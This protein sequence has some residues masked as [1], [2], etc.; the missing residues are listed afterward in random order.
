M[1]MDEGIA[2][3]T[4]YTV[5]ESRRARRVSLRITFRGELEVVVPGRFD[6]RRIPALVAG[7]RK[8]IERTSERIREER[9]LIGQHLFDILPAKVDLPALGESWAV[10][11]VHSVQKGVRLEELPPEF[12][13]ETG[14]VLIRGDVGDARSCRNALRKWVRRRAQQRLGPMLLDASE[15]TGLAFTGVGFR[16]AVTRWASCSGSKSISLNPKLVFLPWQLVRY[17]F[18]HE[19]AHTAHPNHSGRFWAFLASL[20]P[21][22]RVLDKQVRKAW[23]LVPLW[24]EQ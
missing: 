5:R 11:Y 24:M 9:G 20:E 19:L 12:E 13:G 3:A 15:E 18:L 10:D 4:P 6:R 22:C 14:H 23:K 8:W 16:G 17:V 7:K 2:G 21:E 1:L